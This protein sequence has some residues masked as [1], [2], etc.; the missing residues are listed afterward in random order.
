MSIPV[1]ACCIILTE[2]KRP[3]NYRTCWF[4][5]LSVKKRLY[6]YL[7]VDFSYLKIK[8]N[9]RTGTHWYLLVYSYFKETL[10]PV[11]TCWFIL[12]T[13]IPN[14]C[15]GIYLLVYS[16]CK[17]MSVPDLPVGLFLLKTNVPY[18]YPTCCL[19]SV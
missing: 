10:V 15:T 16:N 12:T 9:A 17:E 1:P 4:I 6:R 13:S 3:Y 18:Q 5:G 2:N 19:S 11:P 7:P 8:T 14:T